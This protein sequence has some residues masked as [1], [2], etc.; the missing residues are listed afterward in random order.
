V[1]RAGADGVAV[2]SAVCGAPDPAAAT[3]E[4]LAAIRAERDLT[5]RGSL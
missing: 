1:I 4:F 2:V 5:R 3:R